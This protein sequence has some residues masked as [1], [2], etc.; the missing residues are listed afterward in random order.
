MDNRPIGVFDS[1]V[2]GLTSINALNEVLP[3]ESIIYF[4]DTARTPYGS[5]SPRTICEF[6]LQI[7]D[8]L[9]KQGVKMLIIA[10][11]TITSVALKEIQKAHPTMLVQGII[12]P[13][14]Q[15]V[16]KVCNKDNSVGIIA[17]M[18]TTQ[19]RAYENALHALKGDLNVHSQA[20]PA[21][22]PLIEEGAI[23]SETMDTTIHHYLDSF[24]EQHK[25]DTLV[26]G[27]THYPIIK[28]EIEKCCP[29]IKTIIDPSMAL[30]EAAE[31]MLGIHDMLAEKKTQKNIFYASDLSAD[32]VNMIN[33]LGITGDY[34][35]EQHSF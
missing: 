4:G 33:R 31:R 6:S 9:E 23:E 32:F 1:G 18:V 11:N 12:E 13:A 24:V 35:L 2:G 10:C 7:A 17:T 22:V 26:L 21:F 29:S 3:D 16:A 27:C 15:E 5:K 25:I 19:S 30:A 14:A 34:R 20:C 28:K 8:F